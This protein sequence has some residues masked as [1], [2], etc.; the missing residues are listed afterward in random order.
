MRARS[1]Q[2]KVQQ[3]RAQPVLLVRLRI[4]LDTHSTRM[5]RPI[6]PLE[7]RCCHNGILVFRTPM[8]VND[9]E[10][11][12]PLS[13]WKASFQMRR[14]LN[15]RRRQTSRCYT[16]RR[17]CSKPH[18]IFLVLLRSDKHIT[19]PAS[20]PDSMHKTCTKSRVDTQP[21]LSQR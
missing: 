16:A 18:S 2:T 15:L 14:H 4:H 13:P 19:A 11:P 5:N 21:L 6:P 10:L 7:P 3:E 1:P 8:S 12:S 9:R 20:I 17:Q